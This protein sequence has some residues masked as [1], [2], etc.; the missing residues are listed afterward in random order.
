MR[1]QG[2]FWQFKARRSIEY[3]AH[4]G[5]LLVAA[6]RTMKRFDKQKEPAALIFSK[7]AGS[8]WAH[9][10]T[11][12]NQRLFYFPLVGAGSHHILKKRTDNHKWIHLVHYRLCVC[13]SGSWMIDKF[14]FLTAIRVS[15]LHLGQYNGKLSNIVSSRI[16]NRVLLPQKGHKIHSI[17]ILSSSVLSFLLLTFAKLLWRLLHLLL[18]CPKYKWKEGLIR[19]SIRLPIARHTWSFL[20]HPRYLQYCS[21]FYFSTLI[22]LCAHSR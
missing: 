22:T 10:I 2:F 13:A 7:A 6:I 12:S 17:F 9:K 5:I 15:C 21:L 3:Q 19:C 18:P 11:C 16:F 14:S 20:L 1:E 8:K 4:S